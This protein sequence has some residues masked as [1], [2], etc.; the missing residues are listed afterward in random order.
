MFGVVQYHPPEIMRAAVFR[1]KMQAAR[2]LGTYSQ[3]LTNIFRALWRKDERQSGYQA[4][5]VDEQV[6]LDELTHQRV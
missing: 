1:P 2:I 4:H 3:I 5:R 6:A